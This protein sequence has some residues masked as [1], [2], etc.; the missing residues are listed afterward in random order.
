MGV[1]IGVRLLGFGLQVSGRKDESTSLGLGFQGLGLWGV[2]IR[3]M[4][5]GFRVSRVFLSPGFF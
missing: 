5:L 1:R 4:L 3:A 2:R